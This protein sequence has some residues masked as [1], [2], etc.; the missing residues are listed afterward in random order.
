MTKG[1]VNFKMSQNRQTHINTHE[2]LRRD[3]RSFVATTTTKDENGKK[4]AKEGRKG[5]EE[6]SSSSQM[7]ARCWLLVLDD[8]CVAKNGLTSTKTRDFLPK[9]IRPK[10]A[11]L[12]LLKVKTYFNNSQ[13]SN[14]QLETKSTAQCDA[15]EPREVV[16]L[17]E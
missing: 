7:S 10:A 1:N 16:K 14:E 6:I 9:G 8:A 15:L 11:L 4:N 13:R 2:G 17:E 5:R 3:R 12:A